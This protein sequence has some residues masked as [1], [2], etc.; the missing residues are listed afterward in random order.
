[1]AHAQTLRVG[2][3]LRAPRAAAAFE[4][5]SISGLQRHQENEYVKI[6]RLRRKKLAFIGVILNIGVLATMQHHNPIMPYWPI[7]G[8]FAIG[9]PLITRLHI[10]MLAGLDGN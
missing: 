8:Q 4:Y 3:P 1:M 7:N 10:V 6:R 5:G 9:L 2:E